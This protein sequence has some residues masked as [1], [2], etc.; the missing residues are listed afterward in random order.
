MDG[1]PRV[2]LVDDDQEFLDLAATVLARRG[3]FAVET[4]PGPSAAFD[5]VERTAVDCV[6]SDHDMDGETGLDLFERLRDGG[7]TV[8][9]VLY[10]AT[11]SPDLA[12]RALA[13]GV[14]DVVRKRGGRTEF[15][16]LANRVERIVERTRSAARLEA[17]LDAVPD[18]VFLLDDDRRLVRWNDTFERRRDRPVAVGDRPTEFV[19]LADHEAASAALRGVFDRDE[20]VKHDVTVRYDDGRERAYEVRMVRVAL[21]GAPHVLG[22]ARDVT[23]RRAAERSEHETERVLAELARNTDDVL[24]VFD[25]DFS[26]L[27]FVNESYERV[28]GGSTETLA[29]D[30]QSFIETVHPDDRDRVRDAMARLGAGESVDMEYRVCPPDFERWVWARAEPVVEDETVVRVA[31]FSRDVT[32]R[33]ERER[34]IEAQNERL[35]RLASIVSHDLQSPLSVVEGSIDL[36][37]EDAGADAERNLARAE[38]ALDR[39][40][41]LTEDILTVAR[42]D[43]A[44]G[45]PT[46]V[47]LSTVAER[48][49]DETETTGARLVVE[50]DGVVDADR[51]RL[52]Q[53]FANLF[54]NA[55]THS[56]PDDADPTDELV[57][58]VGADDGGFY[59]ADDGAGVPEGERESV[60]EPAYTTGRDGTGLGL[61]IVRSVA[62]AH[63]WSVRLEPSATGGARFVVAAPVRPP[64]EQ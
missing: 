7:E 61:D 50:G 18:P 21:D 27:V 14:T 26:E 15:V 6:V 49:W 28:Y 31:G 19:D 58:R 2:L 33:I 24:W 43:E 3:S 37:R 38:R 4:A 17:V 25:A 41:A 16:V 48:A 39:T 23:E 44:V 51:E 59:V 55:A 5:A 47:R 46:P 34:E 30:P 52:R 8:P 12:E 64:A 35:E 63:G 20:T 11:D 53:L 54:D 36:A 60:F 40:R 10:T 56:R 22:V 9:F 1:R 32:D 42:E 29:A 57:V 62:E 13:A 45:E